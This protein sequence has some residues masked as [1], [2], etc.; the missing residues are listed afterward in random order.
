MS[1][2]EVEARMAM[3]KSAMTKLV[4][5]GR[6]SAQPALDGCTKA[7]RNSAWYAEFGCGAD[8]LPKT[9]M[10]A[11]RRVRG[12]RRRK[13]GLSGTAS[14]DSFSGDLVEENASPGDPLPKFDDLLVRPSCLSTSCCSAELSVADGESALDEWSALSGGDCATDGGLGGDSSFSGGAVVD[15]GSAQH[16]R[17]ASLS[18]VSGDGV[19]GG[20]RGG[21]ASVSGGAVV[22]ADAAMGAV[23]AVRDCGL[24]MQIDGVEHAIYCV[25]PSNIREM[26]R[27]CMEHAGLVALR[28]ER[29]L[30][31]T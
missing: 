30:Q 24:D 2:D 26:Y 27:L 3:T 31:Q 7:A 12:G 10:A 15:A 29:K 6:R 23:A 16:E 18:T 1:D 25:D 17:Q 13:V 19:T 11:K 8:Q 20:E 14:G 22:D 28:K 5:A 9:G 4:E 21:D